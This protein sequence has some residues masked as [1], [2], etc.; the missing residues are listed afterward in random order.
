MV[1]SSIVTKLTPVVG[2]FSQQVGT[3][4]RISAEQGLLPEYAESNALRREEHP[5]GYW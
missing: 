1:F 3:S 2:E 5:K 4:S